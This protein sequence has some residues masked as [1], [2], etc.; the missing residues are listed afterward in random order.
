VK[1]WAYLSIGA[2]YPKAV[3]PTSH[4]QRFLMKFFEGLTNC[5]KRGMKAPK[6]EANDQHFRSRDSIW[7]HATRSFQG[8]LYG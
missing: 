5:S 3:W 6:I 2:Q 7:I 1:A 8:S 4:Y